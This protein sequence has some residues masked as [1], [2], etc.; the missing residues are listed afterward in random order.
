MNISTR[1][2]N[3]DKINDE[4]IFNHDKELKE[5]EILFAKIENDN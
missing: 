4:N 1:N 2:I 3:I 5:L